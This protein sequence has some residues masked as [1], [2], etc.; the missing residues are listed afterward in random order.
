M[1][2]Y[3]AVHANP[4]GAGDTR[5]TALQIIQDEGLEGKLAGKVIVL[6]G[7]TSGIGLETARALSATGATLLLTARDRKKAE[8]SL[9]GI[10]DPGRISI[11]DMENA[12][13]SSVR[14]AAQ[15]ILSQSHGKVNIFIA[16]AGIMGTPE[17]KLT[18]DGHE[19]QFS[20]NHLSHFLLFHLLKDALLAASTPDF[21]SRAV[22]VASS[23]HR[24]GRLPASDDYS[25]QKTPYKHEA[26]YSNS[27]LA[28]VYTASFI[29]RHYGAMGLHATSLHPGGILTNIARSL[30]PA[31]MD[32]IKNMPHLIPMFKS[33]EQGAATT[34]VAAVG[35]EWEGK[36][37]K[38]LEDCEEAKR[39]TDDGD[40][41]QLG[42]TSWTYD[43]GEEERLWRDSL[44]LVGVED[45]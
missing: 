13:F 28:N 14:A 18:E 6:T 35:K 31:A 12:S 21:N 38:Y 44:Q 8:E 16:N 22:F 2:R 32:A 10:L 41:F 20:V 42:Y 43:E 1:G 15:Q 25:F 11:I 40:V 27:K 26:A 34:V 3:T 23:A 29:D 17:L 19:S 9:A 4:S 39:G 30:D 7:A 33:A 37:G 45:V 5:P 24:G 36:G